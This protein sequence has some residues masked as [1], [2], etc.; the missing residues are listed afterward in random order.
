MTE[1]RIEDLREAHFSTHRVRDVRALAAACV[2]IVV[3]ASV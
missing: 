2:R 1:E 3:D